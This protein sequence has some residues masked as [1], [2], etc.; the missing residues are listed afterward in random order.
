MT[1][2]ADAGEVAR[3]QRDDLYGISPV[4]IYRDYWAIDNLST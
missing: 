1:L 4:E 2:D 3:M